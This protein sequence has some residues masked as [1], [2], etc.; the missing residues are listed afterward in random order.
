MALGLNVCSIAECGVNQCGTAILIDVL[1]GEAYKQPAYYMITHFSKYLPQNSVRIEH[2]LSANMKDLFVL[3]MKRP[4]NMS[5]I[6]VLN[7]NNNAIELTINESNNHNYI[8]HEIP[9]RSIQTYILPK[10]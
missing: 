4:D 8:K 7:Q 9:G 1:K 2:K 3:S 10:D 5:V 6:V